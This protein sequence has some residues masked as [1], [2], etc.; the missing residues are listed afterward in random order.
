MARDE[1][2]HGTTATLAGADPLPVPVRGLMAVG[3]GVLRAA[4]LWV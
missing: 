3:G 4:A 1:R 2:H